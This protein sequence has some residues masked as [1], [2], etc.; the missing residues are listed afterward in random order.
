[1]S[2]ISFNAK[3]ETPKKDELN[4]FQEALSIIDKLGTVKVHDRLGQQ[5]MKAYM[6]YRSINQNR[7][8]ISLVL[9]LNEDEYRDYVEHMFELYYALEIFEATYSQAGRDDAIGVAICLTVLPRLVDLLDWFDN[10]Y[11]MIEDRW[12]NNPEDL[13]LEVASLF[14]QSCDM[15]GLDQEEI[16]IDYDNLLDASRSADRYVIVD[17]NGLEMRFKTFKDKGQA[18]TYIMQNKR[19]KR[20]NLI[21]RY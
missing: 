19:L 1:M 8:A 5:Y 10:V 20:D 13:N 15:F 6:S 16:N 18:L 21:E 17:L 2:V 3:K 7:R 14:V 12:E 4:A 11:T 9:G